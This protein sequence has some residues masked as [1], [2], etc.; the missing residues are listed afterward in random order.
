MVLV[1][2]LASLVVITSCIVIEF[3]GFRGDDVR[4]VVASRLG[5]KVAVSLQ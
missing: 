2:P 4:W 5:Q 1:P 3:V